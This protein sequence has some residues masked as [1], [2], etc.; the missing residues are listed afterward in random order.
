MTYLLTRAERRQRLGIKSPNTELKMMEDGLLTRP[1]VLGQ[2]M[3]RIPS[4]E[5]EAIIKA[6]LS[7]K[8]KQEI[9]QL[10]KSLEDNRKE[11]D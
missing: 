8:S 3:Q 5:I 2:R 11:Y 6:H 7:G 1:I 4:N 9:K 10:V